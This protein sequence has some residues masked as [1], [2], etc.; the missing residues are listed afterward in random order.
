MITL[1]NIKLSCHKCISGHRTSYCDHI[2]EYEL[3]ELKPKG[4]PK[5]GQQFIINEYKIHGKLI[6]SYTTPKECCNFA[7]EALEKP[8]QCTK[9][10]SCC[11]K[12]CCSDAEGVQCKNCVGRCGCG[13]GH[14]DQ[15]CNNCAMDL[16][17]KYW[18]S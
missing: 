13:C 9:C 11:G 15:E 7:V 18:V 8:S 5:R 6:H 12:K 2:D 14:T 16:C 1:G 4:R 3:Y 10:E 17:P